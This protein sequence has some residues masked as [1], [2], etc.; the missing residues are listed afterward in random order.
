MLG[1]KKRSVGSTRDKAFTD[2]NAY[3]SVTGKV[4]CE[5]AGN[6]SSKVLILL[7]LGRDL[8]AYW[9]GA[10]GRSDCAAS[11]SKGVACVAD[12]DR[13][14]VVAHLASKA[15]GDLHG[16]LTQPA[17]CKHGDHA[18]L[19][20]RVLEPIIGTASGMGFSRYELELIYGTTSIP[21]A[22]IYADNAGNP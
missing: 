22:I 14:A 6:C 5:A 20:G 9:F 1:E 18:I 3:D 12:P 8:V 11:R 15:F 16:A 7:I 21:A 13:H 2:Q 17:A 19:A 4:G 10:L